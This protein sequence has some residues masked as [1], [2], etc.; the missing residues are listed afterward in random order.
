MGY[1]PLLSK[2]LDRPAVASSVLLTSE[3]QI[4]LDFLHF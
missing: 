4:L 2:E 1:I 3:L